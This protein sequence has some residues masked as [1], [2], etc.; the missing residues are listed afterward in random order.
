MAILSKTSISKDAAFQ[1]GNDPI[2]FYFQFEDK[3]GHSYE[4]NV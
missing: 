1:E 2:A 3:G 4:G